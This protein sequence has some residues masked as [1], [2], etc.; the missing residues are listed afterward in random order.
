MAI[1]KETL[2]HICGIYFQKFALVGVTKYQDGKKNYVLP[3]STVTFE[4]DPVERFSRFRSLYQS[5]ERGKFEI[6]ANSTPDSI[7]LSARSKSR[8]GKIDQLIWI[9]YAFWPCESQQNHWDLGTQTDITKISWVYVWGMKTSICLKTISELH[10]IYTT[11]FPVAPRMQ[12]LLSIHY[13]S[14]INVPTY[15]TI[16]RLIL[17]RRWLKLATWCQNKMQHYQHVLRHCMFYADKDMPSYWVEFE[18]SLELLKF[19]FFW[20]PSLN[21]IAALKVPNRLCLFCDLF[22]I[23][24]FIR[25]VVWKSKDNKSCKI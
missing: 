17:C 4:R 9:K 21:I 5:S 19:V 23:A 25:P 20:A 11:Y 18:R 13:R 16:F 2:S 3:V 7:H 14:W 8:C 24:R 15:S 12:T 6:F 22:K 1:F 10:T